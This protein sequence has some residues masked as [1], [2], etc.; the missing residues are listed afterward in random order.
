MLWAPNEMYAS[1]N[2]TWDT[3]VRLLWR[4]RDGRLTCYIC[5]NR[6]VILVRHPEGVGA[7]VWADLVFVPGYWPGANMVE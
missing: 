4:C 5:V 1:S 3:R 2:D 7:H 6:V